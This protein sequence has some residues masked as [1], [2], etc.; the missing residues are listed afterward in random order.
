MLKKIIENAFQKKL[1]V[2]YDPD[3]TIFY[4]APEDLALE[5]E[6]FEFT[7]D[8]GQRLCGFFYKKGEVTRRELIV[9]EH[10]MGCGHRSYLREIETICNM[11]YEVFT[12]DHTG[13]RFSEG[14][15]I[16]GFTQSLVDLD[17]AITTLKA[18]GRALGRSIAVIGHSWGG[19]STLNIAALHPDLTHTVALAGYVSVE[20]MLED[21]L[22][23]LKGYAPELLSME[24]ERFGSYSYADARYSL[25]ASRNT[26]TLVMHSS[27]DKTCSYRNF[28]RIK[29]SLAGREGLTLISLD[30]K[31][32]NPN[33][34]EVAVR[35]K[36]EFFAELTRMKKKKRLVTEEQKT[37]FLALFDWRKM[38][39]QD[40]GVW[41]T[42][43]DFI[44]S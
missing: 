27:D 15:N 40:E 11:G 20:A 42:I 38:T 37:D 2:R 13:T 9:F 21:L 16:G 12:Y 3:G 28:E 5:C 34:T 7:G 18:S 31:G 6:S 30:N 32:H 23:G 10:G 8:R 4:F 1:L 26:K 25:L 41:A 14:E 44:E 24:A 33:Y 39:E 43:F 36:D 22:G 17:R 35:Y 19:Y 29:N